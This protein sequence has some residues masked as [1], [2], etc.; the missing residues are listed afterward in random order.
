MAAIIATG[1]DGSRITL[2]KGVNKI[3]LAP[4]LTWAASLKLGWL[5]EII[6]LED[7]SGD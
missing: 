6:E 1:P 2:L 7:S 3:V 5:I 4:Y